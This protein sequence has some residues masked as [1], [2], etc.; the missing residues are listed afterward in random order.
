MQFFFAETVDDV[1][2]QTIPHT[3]SRL[4]VV[5][6]DGVRTNGPVQAPTAAQAATPGS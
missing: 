3:A 4:G 1:L 2:A 5:T 6:A